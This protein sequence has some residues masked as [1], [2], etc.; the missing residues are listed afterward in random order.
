MPD[1]RQILLVGG[2][3][4]CRSCID[5][6]ERLGTFRIAGIVERNAE[7]ACGD[8]LG[9]PVVG[10]DDELSALRE[11]AD[12][13]L[14]TVGQIH[15]CIPRLT[16]FRRLRDQGFALPVIVSPYAVVS[17]H[18]RLGAG[19]V[20]MHGAVVN[21]GAVVGENC[22]LNTK[23]LVEHDARIGAHCHI[24][25]GAIVNGNASVGDRS[26]VGSHATVVNDVDVEAGAFVRAGR[27]RV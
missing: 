24:S 21:A 26:F 5:V 27:V 13:A 12:A 17:P 20:V 2:G 23:A 15:D 14:V 19:T 11:R 1:R 8:V 3:G 25:T 22:I 4:H 9:Y 7:T 6:I 10:S 16:L 18:S